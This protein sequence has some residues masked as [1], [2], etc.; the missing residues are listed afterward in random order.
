M[1]RKARV[2]F[3]GALY[4]VIVRGNQRQKIFRDERDRL[5][6]LQRIEHYRKRYGFALYAYVYAALQPA[7]STA[8]A[9]KEAALYFW[10]RHLPR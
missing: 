5:S 1:A 9:P 3:E 7:S 10:G 4:H 6:Y 2:E 8:T